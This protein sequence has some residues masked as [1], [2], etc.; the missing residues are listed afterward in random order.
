MQKPYTIKHPDSEMLCPDCASKNITEDEEH[1]VK[2]T[3]G[4]KLKQYICKDCNAV[5]IPALIG[6]TKKSMEKIEEWS[7]KIKMTEGNGDGKSW[8]KEKPEYII[9][10]K[11]SK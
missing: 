11:K 1:D 9:I 2:R 7:N 3:S 6:N 8:K 4:E 10:T 5:F